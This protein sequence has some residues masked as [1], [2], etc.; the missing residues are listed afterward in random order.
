MENLTQKPLLLL[1]SKDSPTYSALERWNPSHESPLTKD[2]LSTAISRLSEGM[3]PATPKEYAESLMG[4]IQF[5]AA[6]GIACPDP[7]AVQA[8]YHEQLS[9]LPADL[10]NLAIARV[11]TT[12]IWG[13]RMPFPAD[14]LNKVGEEFT[15]RRMLLSRAKVAALKVQD[16]DRPKNVIAPEKWKNLRRMLET[17]SQTS[18]LR[19]T[20]VMSSKQ[21]DEDLENMD[22]FEER[23]RQF[24]AECEQLSDAG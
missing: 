6:F 8:I 1:T 24:I 20:G 3:K 13:N 7:K 5:A 9:H 14:I 23:K 19:S 16:E 17:T 12:W 4:L 2:E 11:K 21:R 15:R 22:E 10:L 18:H